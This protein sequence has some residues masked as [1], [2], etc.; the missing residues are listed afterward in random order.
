[1]ELSRFT[2]NQ[3]GVGL[4]MTRYNVLVDNLTKEQ[5]EEFDEKFVAVGWTIKGF[6]TIG[7]QSYRNYQWESDEL[8]PV[9]PTVQKQ[10]M[11]SNSAD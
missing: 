10:R 8:K 5:I 9:Y 3:E 7:S 4:S 6:S 11:E 2:T 1:M